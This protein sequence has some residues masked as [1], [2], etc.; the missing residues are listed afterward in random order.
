MKKPIIGI[1]TCRDGLKFQENKYFQA[2]VREGQNLGATVFIFAHRDVVNGRAVRGF[3]PKENGTGWKSSIYPRPDA[4]IDRCRRPV[5]EARG[6]RKRHNYLF[7][8]SKFSNKWNVTQLFS[9]EQLLNRWIPQTKSYSRDNLSKMIEEYPTLYIKPGNGTGGRSIVRITTKSNGY[10]LIGRT[11]RQ[12]K[13]HEHLKTFNSLYRYNSRWVEKEKIR[14]GHFMIQQGLDLELLPNRVVDMRLLIQKNELGRW[15]VT[16]L[17]MRIGGKNSPTSN[18]HGGGTAATAESILYKRFGEEKGNTI[19]QESHQLAHTV[20]IIVEKHF[21]R[22]MELG[23]DIG[24]DL[25][26]RIWLIEVNPKPGRDV[27]KK[28]GKIQQYRTAVQRPIQYAMYLI[29]NT[30]QT[31][32]KEINEK[33]SEMP[34]E[35]TSEEPSA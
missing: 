33:P 3:T 17:G 21:G 32:S 29:K 15:E 30:Q 19:I 2:L 20:A 24:V 9:K 18:L 28:M 25:N 14:N 8:N 13:R 4:V 27:F 35:K 34:N 22:M 10:E 26:G 5:A 31:E 11:Y 16:G 12:Q 23:L 1:L 7:V 6:F